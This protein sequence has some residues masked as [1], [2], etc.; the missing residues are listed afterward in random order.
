VVVICLAV[1]TG[2]DIAARRRVVISNRHCPQRARGFGSGT[3]CS[4]GH[5]VNTLVNR[6]VPSVV[7]RLGSQGNTGNTQ[8]GRVLW[9]ER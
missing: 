4:Y 3:V 6:E 5:D 2:N 9:E 8:Q 1:N 7:A